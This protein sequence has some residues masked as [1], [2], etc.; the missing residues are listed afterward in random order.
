MMLSTTR[1]VL[2]GAT[3]CALLA[4]AGLPG[5]GNGGASEPPVTSYDPAATSKMQFAVGVATISFSTASGGTKV[6]DGLDIVE[7]LRQKDGLS[8]TLYNVPMVIGPSNFDVY[9]STETGSVVQSAGSDLGTNH[10]TWA[11]LNQE[12]W[13]G[14]PRGIK[15]SSTGAFGYGLCPCNSDSGPD[16]GFTPLFQAFNLPIYGQQSYS[17]I[18]LW[19]GG[20]PAFPA[21]GPSVRALGWLG[22][23]LGFS[24]FAIAPV[25]GKYNLYAAVPPAYDTPQN[26]T[27][28]PG[29]N[30]TPTPAPG[31]L[32]AGAQLADLTLL[33]VFSTPSFKP[34]GKGGGTIELTVPAGV[35]EAMAEVFTPLMS[36]EKNSFCTKAHTTDSYY[37]VVTYKTGAQGLALPDDIGPLTDSGQKTPSICPKASYY[38]YAVGANWPLYESSY[39]NNLSQLPLIKGSNGQADITTSAPFSGEYPK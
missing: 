22:Y 16:N 21:A 39:P 30:G 1:V 4:L 13:T 9:T 26:P 11:T 19:Y 18:G 20:P 5:C 25:V 24:D 32:A 34:D 12:A 31:I 8:G 36:G 7:T 23:S 10:I 37:S 29:P 33:P 35:H 17:G 6:A 38:V 2:G 27:P 14:P 3:V 28:S 15:A